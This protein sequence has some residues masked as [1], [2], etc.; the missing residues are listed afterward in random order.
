MTSNMNGPASPDGARLPALTPGRETPMTG[1]D[2][3]P[4]IT[5]TNELFNHPKFKR[6]K[7]PWARLHLIEL[8]TYCNGYKTDG[9][10]DEDTLMEKGDD[11]GQEL[12]DRKWVVGP[13]KDGNYH[14]HDYLKHQKSKAEIEGMTAGRKAA[15]GWGNHVRWHVKKQVVEH[16]CG[17]CTGELAPIY[18]KGDTAE[19]A[20]GPPTASLTVIHG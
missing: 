17:Y 9:V 7:N 10:I 3:R 13:D 12:L 14:M 16:S 1:K 5:L 15:A 11:V 20:P 4:Y 2:T 6:I 18:G 8:W 19:P